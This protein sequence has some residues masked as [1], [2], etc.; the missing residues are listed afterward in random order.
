MKGRV[1]G[2]GL[3]LDRFLVFNRIYL[4]LFLFSFFFFLQIFPS[5]ISF[6]SILPFCVCVYTS[7]YCWYFFWPIVLFSPSVEC[8]AQRDF[9]FRTSPSI[10]HI[11][12]H[13]RSC[14][15]TVVSNITIRKFFHL[16][17]HSELHYFLSIFATKEHTHTHIYIYIYIY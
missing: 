11:P 12:I 8:I 14:Q 15:I 16:S 5:L 1:F 17:N 4:F 3:R 9:F 13:N 10:H 2:C 6:L 7:D